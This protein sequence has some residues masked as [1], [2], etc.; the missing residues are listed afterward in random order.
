MAGEI[1]G[2]VADAFHQVAV[3]RDHVG[4]M[5]DQLRA[6][7][8]AQMT[9]RQR[10]A[11]RVGEALAERPGGG[12]D[13]GRM[14]VLGMA[15]GARAELA[16]ALELLDL[17]LRIA[18]QMEQRV[19]QHRA[20]AGGQHEAVAIGPVGRA[21]IELEELAEQHGRDVGHAHRQAGMAGIGGLH[22]IHRERADGV[23]EIVVAG[24]AGSG[25]GGGGHGVARTILGRAVRP[26]R[27]VSPGTANVADPRQKS[28]RICARSGPR[29]RTAS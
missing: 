6:E 10:H 23:G 19:E 3:A 1:A 15:G 11:D 4:A 25:F 24:Q 18:G 20:M 9:L 27:Q 5:I 28:T 29:R 2:L 26:A 16:E 8:G 21:R 22:R 14:A 7:A 12:L 13:A 17:H